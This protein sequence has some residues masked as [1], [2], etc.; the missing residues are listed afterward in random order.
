MHKCKVVS[1]LT[2]IFL[3]KIFDEVSIVA[4]RQV[5]DGMG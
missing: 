5:Y 1:Q 3:L 4:Q 2:M